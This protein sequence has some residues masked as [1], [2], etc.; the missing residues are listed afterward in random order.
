MRLGTKEW[1]MPVF[2]APMAGF[3]DMS[4]RTLAREYGCDAAFT[5]MVSAKALGY[6]NMKTCDLLELS[7][8]EKPTVI[9]I[10]GRE[11]KVM[12][13]AAEW[14]SKQP[15]VLAIDINMGCPAPKIVKN[16]E[17]SA[18]MKEPLLAG[19][20][21]ESVVKASGVPVTVKIRKGFDMEH[22]NAVEIA[23]I[24]EENG[25]SMITVHGRNREQM[26]S[27]KAD[28]ESIA[29]V[30]DAVHIP[31]I[32][33]G[34]ICDAD[35]AKKMLE[36]TGC[37]GIMIGRAALGNPWVFEQIK[38]EW[39]GR[40]SLIPTLQERMDVAYRHAEMTVNSKGDHGI[41][42]LRKHIVCYLKGCRG[43]A[44]LR[45]RI[46]YATTLPE[47]RQ[48]LLDTDRNG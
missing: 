29:H 10:F 4:F 19:Q 36:E 12:A 46:Q 27:G 11:P 8:E 48:I 28:L 5:E 1:E 42:E 39:A 47:L 22:E 33:N 32:G 16:G 15:G 21:I 20:I 31:V 7:E 34:D 44:E 25:A 3:S 41:I 43:A 17:G 13:N 35:S 30:K 37:D 26:Y 2:L 6:H 24:A 40:A 23:V 14:I 18:L 9:Q 38:A 45:Q